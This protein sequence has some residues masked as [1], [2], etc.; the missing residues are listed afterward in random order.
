M[1]PSKACYEAAIQ[2]EMKV[3][4]RKS[5]QKRTIKRRR[6]IELDDGDPVI[7]YTASSSVG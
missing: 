3:T 1:F 5:K 6:R 7:L 4:Q 2:S